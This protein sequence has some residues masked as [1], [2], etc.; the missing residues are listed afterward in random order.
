VLAGLRLASLVLVTGFAGR[1]EAGQITSLAPVAASAHATIVITGTGFDPSPGNNLVTLRASTGEEVSTTP[2]TV[3]LVDAAK[4]FRRLNV[5]VPPGLPVGRATVSVRNT[6]T[7]ELSAGGTVDVVSISLPEVASAQISTSNLAVRIVG[8]PNIQ[9]VPG[10]RVTFGQGI[11]VVSLTRES[12]TALVAQV[13]IDAGAV[14]GLRAVT[15]TANPARAL[16]A[17][18][19]PNGFAVNNTP[20][21]PPT[22]TLTGPTSGLLTNVPQQTVTGTVSDPSITSGALRINGVDLPLPIVKGQFSMPVTLIEGVT[23]LMATAS[24]AGGPGASAEVVVTLDTVPPTLTARLP[25]GVE[26]GSQVTVLAEAFDPSGVA[27]VSM[28]AGGVQTADATAPYLLPLSIPGNALPGT[29]RMVEIT[30]RD[31]VGNERSIERAVVVQGEADETAPSVLLTLPE[32]ATAGELIPVQVSAQDDQ[33]LTQLTIAQ[34]ATVLRTLAGAPFAA[35]IPFAIPTD[36][37]VGQEIGFGATAVDA[38]GNEGGASAIVRI[39]AAT[40]DVPALRL[41]VN[42]V[43]SPT[44]LPTQVVTGTVNPVDVAATHTPRAFIASL[45]VTEGG[46]GDRLNVPILGANSNFQSGVSEAT[47]G[48][49]I[50]VNALQVSSPTEILADITIASDAS[51]GPRLVAVQTGPEEALLLNAFNIRSGLGSISGRLLDSNNQPLANVEVCVPGSNVCVR[52]D[53]T[54]AFSI[55]NAPSTATRVA[56]SVPGLTQISVPIN[57]AVGGTVQLGTIAIDT[58]D[59]PPPPPPSGGPQPPAA[60]AKAL[61][62]GFGETGGGISLAKGRRLI[63]DA[64]IAVGGTEAGVLD[65]TGRQLNPDVVGNGLIT[66]TPDGVRV[67]AHRLERGETVSLGDMLFGWSFGFVWSTGTPPTL[68]EWLETMQGIVNDAWANP[69]APQSMLPILAFNRG[70]VMPSTPPTLSPDTRVGAVQ[71]YLL[72]ASFFATL[73]DSP[74]ARL[75]GTGAPVARLADLASASIES[76]T[77]GLPPSLAPP[78]LQAR[79]RLA[80][81]TRTDSPAAFTRIL[82][83]IQSGP[84]SSKRFTG[85]WRNFFT[86]KQNFATTVLN[87]AFQTHLLLQMALAL[88]AMAPGGLVSTVGG[89]GVAGA[90]LGTVADTLRTSF[91]ALTLAATVPES[92]DVVDARVVRNL[93]ASVQVAI[94][95]RLSSSHVRPGKSST[96]GVAY[97]YSLYR[98]RTTDSERTLVDSIVVTSESHVPTRTIGGTV[99]SR[100]VSSLDENDFR[101]NV[102]LTLTDDEPLPIVEDS[103]GLPVRAATITQFYAVTVTKFSSAADAT[104]ADVLERAVPW[105]NFPLGGRID[106]GGLAALHNRTKHQFVSDYSEPQVVTVNASGEKVTSDGVE[107]DRTTGDVYYS[108]LPDGS[109][110]KTFFKFAADDLNTRSAFSSTGFKGRTAGLAIDSAGT[111]YSNNPASEAQF[112]GR[113]FKFTQPSGAREHTGTMNYYSFLLQFAHPVSIGPSAMAPGSQPTV[114]AE[115]LFAVD[116]LAQ[117]V[118]RV[119]VQ[120]AFDATRRIGQPWAT[121]PFPARSVDLE[122]VEPREGSGVAGDGYLL[123]DSIPASLLTVQLVTADSVVAIGDPFRAT[124]T[125]GNPGQQTVTSVRPLLTFEGAGQFREVSA[126][127]SPIVLEGGRSQSFDIE[128]RADEGGGVVIKAQGQGTDPGGVTISSPLVQQPVEILPPLAVSLQTPPRAAPGEDFTVILEARNRSTTTGLLSVTPVVSAVDAVLSPGEAKGEVAQQSGPTPATFDL[129]PGATSTFSY[130]FRGTKSGRVGFEARGT[131]VN[132]DTTQPMTSNLARGGIN[133][134]PLEITLA[135]SKPVVKFGGMVDATLTVVNTGSVALADVT[136]SIVGSGNGAAQIIPALTPVPLAGGATHVFQFQ[137]KGT[138][139][140]FVLLE[141]VVTATVGGSTVRSDRVQEPFS[142]GPTIR[143]LVLD[144]GFRALNLDYDEDKLFANFIELQGIANVRVAAIDGQ[145]NR[146]EATTGDDGR[147]VLNV[148]HGGPFDVVIESTPTSS[149]GVTIRD[150]RVLNDDALELNIKLPVTL[151]TQA[152]QTAL[153]LRALHLKVDDKGASVVGPAEANLILSYERLTDAFLQYLK[154]FEQ[155]PRTPFYEGLLKGTEREP[156]DWD[157]LERMTVLMAFTKRR[158]DEAVNLSSLFVADVV[159]FAVGKIGLDKISSTFDGAVKDRLLK[160]PDSK[161]LEG[162]LKDLK[163]SFDKTFKQAGVVKQALLLINKTACTFFDGLLGYGYLTGAIDPSEKK[164]EDLMKSCDEVTKNAATIL[165]FMF[166]FFTLKLSSFGPSQLQSAIDAFLKQQG[167]TA[168][169]TLAMNTYI[170]NVTEPLLLSSLRR[171]E[172]PLAVRG[173]TQVVFD[174]LR[175]L[176]DQTRTELLRLLGDIAGLPEADSGLL[177]FISSA[178]NVAEDTF[179]EALKGGGGM[180]GKLIAI[181]VNIDKMKAFSEL[182][183][184]GPGKVCRASNQ[185]FRADAAFTSEPPAVTLFCVEEIPLDRSISQ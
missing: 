126:P 145:S 168:G 4:G 18:V 96:S 11:T 65:E 70:R 112:G 173:D 146:V 69:S 148:E 14:P 166:D 24:N 156:N 139:T 95:L 60:V 163:G 164:H 46:Q 39:V 41:Q 117:Q 8:S 64:L 56:V 151:V 102:V 137:L 184:M 183:V 123:V 167:M 48:A 130:V 162:E 104:R 17:A 134:T 100:L 110:I 86:S 19:L 32:T 47:F 108:V 30:A 105:W 49:G 94:D 71:A 51:I 50:V 133:I 93:D 170:Q 138:K 80:N 172:S 179:F 31:L 76:W 171:L 155:G 5:V 177:G 53:A 121:L 101:R 165:G 36:A 83:T 122:F 9:F 68:T 124:V 57:L 27:S 3:T 84:A 25:L 89:I 75:D 129:A 61:G 85:F 78:H 175:T 160:T 169:I 149:V 74:L 67:L 157:T 63:T 98:F 42:P 10:T 97:A 1:L 118:K 91:Q 185:I 43:A 115:D 58:S 28:D 29:L 106:A 37:Q 54:G 12:L 120:A 140:G 136:P 44:F 159:N 35:Q 7:N 2:V 13:S 22:V 142:V 45:G 77:W 114:S 143:G 73:V 182:S 125:I 6:A 26:P 15:V 132:A 79:A 55:A 87:N 99:I 107:V 158:F 127:P 174:S 52:T 176:D 116:D 20:P 180:I 144:V 135:L 90:F 103:N 23:R 153:R 40:S 16:L 141:A 152:R 181:M 154:R 111:L 147:Y 150:V 82:G 33:T 38:A 66:L 81:D 62:L 128:L 161:L 178:G 21:P 113:I 92:P 88:P 72:T 109:D 119:P 59:I 131:A 34:G